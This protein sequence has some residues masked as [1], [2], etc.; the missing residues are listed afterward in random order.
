MRRRK[1]SVFDKMVLGQPDIL[2]AV[3]FAPRGA[4]SSSSVNHALIVAGCR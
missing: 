2:E 4:I 3:V 1:I